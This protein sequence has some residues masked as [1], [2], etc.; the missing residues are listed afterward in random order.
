ML[1]FLLQQKT[2]IH[3]SVIKVYIQNF[4]NKMYKS[5]TREEE[6]RIHI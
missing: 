4:G 2:L 1:T 6:N 3:E 5:N